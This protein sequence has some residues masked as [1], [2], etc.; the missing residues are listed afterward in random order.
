M[1][2]LVAFEEGDSLFGGLVDMLFVG[3]A[4]GPNRI[5]EFFEPGDDIFSDFEFKLRDIFELDIFDGGLDKSAI[6]TLGEHGTG[7]EDEAHLVFGEDLGGG[8]VLVKEKLPGK[9]NL[10]VPVEHP[11]DFLR[12]QR[13]K[14][15]LRNE[16]KPPAQFEKL[17][18]VRA[19]LP[20]LLYVPGEHCLVALR[21]HVVD[22]CLLELLHE[23][24][25]VCQLDLL[26]LNVRWRVGR[27]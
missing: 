17:A 6:N 2:L 14:L 16:L 12:G 19:L 22:L 15:L 25:L 1:E 4:T 20:Q 11:R 13:L 27:G 10:I 23:Q 9:I 18:V 26:V 5:S 3:F 21:P 8:E 24:R 7:F